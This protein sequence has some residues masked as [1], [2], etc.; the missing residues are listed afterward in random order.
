MKNI[1]THTQTNGD[2]RA[3]SLIKKNGK[4]QK[5]AQRLLNERIESKLNDKSPTQT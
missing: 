4:L 1:K 5:V 3:L 2:V